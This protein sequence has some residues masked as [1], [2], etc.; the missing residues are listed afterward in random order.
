MSSRPFNN[1]LRTLGA[2]EDPVATDTTSDWSAMS[3]LKA[4][5]T[6]LQSAGPAE[7]PQ[8]RTLT[9][10]A[11]L[12][13]GGSLAANRTFDV[14]AG[15]G[16]S[17]GAD[18]VGL[19]DTAVTPA[20]Y[21]SAS[22]VATFTVDQQGRLTAA[23]ST[24]IAINI[25]AV[26]GLQTALDGKV[27]TTVTLTA[28]AG[29]TGGGD[30]SSNRSFAVGAGTGIVANADD[31]AIDKASDANVRAAASNKVM[32]TDRIESASAEVTL[33]DAATVALD[34]D[35]FINGTVQITTNRALGNPTN[36]QP[37]TWRTVRVTS[38]GGPDTLTFGNQYG[39]TP[40]TLDD[41]TTTQHYLVTIYC[42]TTTHFV[43][44]AVDAS[45]P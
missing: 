16:I 43:V 1:W 10:G 11:G 21:G 36:G 22:A 42:V 13:G 37:G 29:L 33:T 9:A 39:G 27:A 24:S 41:I 34:W 26:S 5:F 14:G 20:A 8:S 6:A 4:I 7:V 28:G 31:V 15:T 30:L 12:T 25:S 18:A 35:T 17:V 3:L 40:P 32:T 44:S 19:A 2:P 38:D 45:P 23:G